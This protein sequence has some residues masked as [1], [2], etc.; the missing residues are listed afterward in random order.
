VA[1][2]RTVFNRRLASSTM[3][4]DSPK[5]ALQHKRRRLRRWTLTTWAALGLGVFPIATLSAQTPVSANSVVREAYATVP[6]ARIFYRD[7]GGSGVPVIFLHAATGSSRVWEYQIPA[8]AVAG[9]RVIACGRR[10][11]GIRGIAARYRRGRPSGACSTNWASIGS[12][13]S[14]RQPECSW[15]STSPCRTR[16]GA[17]PGNRQHNRWRAGCRLPR[18][19]ALDS[20]AAI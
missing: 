16:S 14:A 7:T 4:K 11:W 1:L 8:L 6:G 13:W 9:Y 12:T 5:T 15:Y 2:A 10:G 20:S 18:T 19:G 17:Q 3:S